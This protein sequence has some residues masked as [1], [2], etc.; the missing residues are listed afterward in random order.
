MSEYEDEEI[1]EEQAQFIMDRII[2]FT[3]LGYKMPEIIIK[4]QEYSME[5]L[6]RIKRDYEER[7]GWFTKQ[8]LREFELLRRKR[9]ERQALENLS[10]EE[11]SRYEEEK[12]AEEQRREER[13][14][15]RQAEFVEMLRANN[16][17]KQ[18]NTKQGRKPK[19]NLNKRDKQS[20]IDDIDM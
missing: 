20:D 10:P 17:M 9:K 6:F 15:N 19:T 8:E 7:N 11:R 3:K 16:M 12:K 1:T 18:E 2:R 13:I 4:M 5:Q 14:K